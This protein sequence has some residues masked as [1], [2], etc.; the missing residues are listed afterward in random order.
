ML[1]DPDGRMVQY[2]RLSLTK[3]CAMRCKYC[4]P[5]WIKNQ[6]DAGELTP[7]EIH[8]LVKHLAKHHQLKKVRLTGGDPTSRSDLIEVIQAVSKVK[9]IQDLAMTTHGLTLVNQAQAYRDAGVKRLNISLDTLNPQ[10]FAQLTGVDQ[11]ERVCEGIDQALR[12]GFDAIK[13]NT[14]VVKGQ[15]EDD[16]QSLVRFASQKKVAIRFIELMPMGP[17]ADVWSQRYVS[18]EQMKERIWEIVTESEPIIQ[19]HDAAKCYRC[20]L[21]DQRAVTVGFIT[22]MSCN[23]CSDCNRVRIASDGSIYPCLMGEPHGNIMTALRPVFDGEKLDRALAE[24]LASKQ[25]EHPHD[26]F[27]VMTHIG[28]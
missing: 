11:L 8:H 22:P 9:Q 1:T 10:R 15:N 5:D 12:V 24:S 27:V 2:L 14:V 23:F 17:L 6:S 21:D 28:G 19:G 16:M 3:S 13:I 7:N 20:I 4:R 18:Q 25:S 26:G